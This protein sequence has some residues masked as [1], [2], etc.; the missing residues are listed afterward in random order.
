ML[1]FFLWH[2]IVLVLRG[3]APYVECVFLGRYMLA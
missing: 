2:F 3:G 1:A